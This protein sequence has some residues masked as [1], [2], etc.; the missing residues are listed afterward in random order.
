MTAL[1]GGLLTFVISNVANFS[2]DFDDV[3]GRL[4]E[5]AHKVDEWAIN[6]FSYDTALEEKANTDYL[7]NLLNE[8]SSSIGDFALKPWVR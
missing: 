6:T 1:V 7:K 2:K 8:N 4:T 5:Y 3:S